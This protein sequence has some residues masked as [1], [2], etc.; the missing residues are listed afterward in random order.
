MQKSTTLSILTGPFPEVDLFDRFENLRRLV[1]DIGSLANL[2]PQSAMRP[3]NLG[4]SNS[5]LASL[6]GYFSA[7]KPGSE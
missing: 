4:S 6:R 5:N 1:G 7:S 2:H 3:T